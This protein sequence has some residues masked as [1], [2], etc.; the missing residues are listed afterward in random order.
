MSTFLDAV[1]QRVI[2]YD[3]AMGTNIQRYQLGAEDF[4]GQAT[5]GC[6]EY[7]LI[8]KPS[9]IEEIQAGFLE[10]GCDV[11]ETNSF[12]ASRLKLD[13]YGIGQYTHEINLK[14]A[15]LA[16]R[17]ADHYS[18]P[19]QP[20]FVAGSV[21]PTGM[22]PSSDDPALSNITYQQ[23]AEIFREQGAA[24]LEGGVDLFLIE[25]SQ[26][27]LEV[28][29]AI[30]G[31]RRAMREAGRA[32]EVVLQPRHDLGVGGVG[33]TR[34]AGRRHH[35]PVEF[36]HHLLPHLAVLLDLGQVLGLQLALQGFVA[37][38]L[39][40]ALAL[41]VA[42]PPFPAADEGESEDH[43][44]H[45]AQCIFA[46]PAAYAFAL[47]VFVEQ[48]VDGHAATVFRGGGGAAL[49]PARKPGECR[50]GQSDAGWR[51]PSEDTV[52]RA[53]FARWNAARSCKAPPTRTCAAEA[54]PITMRATVP[55][56][57]SRCWP[58]A[59]VPASITRPSKPMACTQ[60][61]ASSASDNV[62]WAG[63]AADIGVKDA[64]IVCVC[65][66]SAGSVGCDGE[67]SSGAVCAVTCARC[68]RVASH[69]GTTIAAV[70]TT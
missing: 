15:Q 63:C 8:S 27:I 23:L 37:G 12:T 46:Y 4:G 56:G 25:T 54:L 21:G 60:L 14:A 50:R 64:T 45:Q 24:L 9:V 57:Y 35:A 43:P 51:R 49:A 55:A 58:A 13:E 39:G 31:L 30:T 33:R 40:F 6:N 17:L 38:R 47:F 42:L 68:G 1:A 26:D 32:V 48:L 16:R 52:K 2:I 20:R 69:T 65:V 11:L 62:A 44:T 10:V 7:L 36:A 53:T 59:S 19:E 61:C 22:L 34:H 3:G 41:L 70:S 29:A 28:R 5:E 67:T 66:G 18:T